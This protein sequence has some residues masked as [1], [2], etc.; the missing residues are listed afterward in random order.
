VKLFSLRN[1]K[2]LGSRV[3]RVQRIAIPKALPVKNIE[4]ESDSEDSD[5]EDE[6]ELATEGARHLQFT[7]DGKRLLIITPDSRVLITNLDI[8]PSE[9]RK[10]KPVITISS[11]VYELDREL[12]SFRA[13]P[14]SKGTHLSK[15]KSRQRQ[16][17]GTHAAYLH[18]IVK[19]N[20]SSTSRLLAIGDLAGNITTFILSP[21]E[22]SWARITTSIPRLP[23]APV[24]LS[25]RPAPPMLQISGSED[26]EDEAPDAELLVLP[27]DTHIIHLFSATS[28]RLA[29]WSQQNPMPDCLP[30]EFA[31]V[32]DRAVGAFWEGTDRAWCFGAAWVWMFDFSREWPNHKLSFDT[33]GQGDNKRKRGAPIGV[34]SISGAGSRMVMP[35]GLKHAPK[36][37]GDESD[38]EEEYPVSNDASEEED[39]EDEELGER[40]ARI[41]KQKGQKPYWGSYRYRS[42]LGFLPVGKREVVEM[43]GEGWEG[44]LSAVEMVVVERPVW[45]VGLPPRFYDG[46]G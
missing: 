20:F 6:V 4:P 8:L 26:D 44:G 13:Y 33:I 3:L 40:K 22:G 29:Q 46:K 11:P 38:A 31:A 23:A 35:I 32:G 17:E 34:G 21:S 30:V 9:D 1:P 42:L 28:G 14:G 43:V 5:D 45:D 19:A 27:A 10:E 12:P 25:F 41:R 39:E 24:V 7:P 37:Q 36:I 16:D 18:T 2:R 15:K